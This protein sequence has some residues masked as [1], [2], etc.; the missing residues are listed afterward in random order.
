[1]MEPAPVRRADRRRIR[2]RWA[3][4]GFVSVGAPFAVALLVV[5][6]AH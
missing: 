1:M 3:I 2:Q 6:V 5:G 4:V